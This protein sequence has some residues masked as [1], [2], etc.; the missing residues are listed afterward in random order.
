MNYLLSKRPVLMGIMNVNPDSFFPPSRAQSEAEMK[1]RMADLLER[2]CTILDIGAVST[3]PGAPDVPPEE[4]WRRLEPALRLAHE[5]MLALNASATETA[6]ATGT[7]HLADMAST[8]ETAPAAAGKTATSNAGF[9]QISIDTFRSEIVRKA[10]A[11][12]GPFIVNDISAGEDDEAML[13]T[14]A[15]LGL[16]Y[17]AMHKRGNPRSMDTFIDYPQGVVTAV[18]EYFDEFS[19]KAASMGIKD[20]IVDPGFGF[21]KTSEQN[22]E[23]L[24]EMK[25]F[26][27]FGRPLLIGVADKR[28][29]KDPLY[30]KGDLGLAEKM[31]WDDADILRI[32]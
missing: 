5:K 3:R 23:L 11:L 29:T 16:P 17:I 9:Y 12:I 22:W 28:F 1:A 15:E 32:H 25:Q 6:P 21:A 10:Y 20:W 31:A 19:R 26:K 4:E 13:E 2:N 24:G 30:N 14:V 18:L 7:A 8:A 27:R